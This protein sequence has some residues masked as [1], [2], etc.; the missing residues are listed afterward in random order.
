MRQATQH[1]EPSGFF[2]IK[3]RLKRLKDEDLLVLLVVLR[4]KALQ[5]IITLIDDPELDEI[6][7]IKRATSLLNRLVDPST[8]TELYHASN[9]NRDVLAALVWSN[10]S[11]AY[12]YRELIDRL[13]RFS[14]NSLVK[15]ATRLRSEGKSDAEIFNDV[16]MNTRLGF[17]ST[18]HKLKYIGAYSGKE[19]AEDLQGVAKIAAWKYLQGEQ[20]KTTEKLDPVTKPTHPPKD[21][22]ETLEALQ[23]ILFQRE[24][25]AWVRAF[26]PLL[27]DTWIKFPNSIRHALQDHY[28]KQDVQKRD[29]REVQYE[30][31]AYVDLDTYEPPL[32]NVE[33]VAEVPDVLDSSYTPSSSEID[34]EQAEYLSGHEPLIDEDEEAASPELTYE[35]Q[36]K[37]KTAEEVNYLFHLLQGP[38]RGDYGITIN[39]PTWIALRGKLGGKHKFAKW[40]KDHFRGYKINFTG[41]LLIRPPIQFSGRSSRSMGQI[42]VEKWQEEGQ[43]DRVRDRVDLALREIETRY[44]PRAAKVLAARAEV[45]TDKEVIDGDGV[46]GPTLRKYKSE[47]QVILTEL[48]NKEN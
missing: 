6:A 44:G 25:E 21:R 26:L 19:T 47:F 40:S 32:S 33:D 20:A 27:D 22:A 7:V 4:A 3:S 46:S 48:S 37:N 34:E 9:R 12:V 10:R 18:G 1:T 2:R 16:L 36:S 15:R 30:D 8:W 14:K 35:E 13:Q 24:V 45:D 5:Q 23:W 28:E 17:R 11:C 29:G 42:R 38:R 31:D 39:P 41:S 43:A